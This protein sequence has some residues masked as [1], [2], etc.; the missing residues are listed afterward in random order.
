MGESVRVPLFTHV[1]ALQD[2]LRDVRNIPLYAQAV[3]C[4]HMIGCT[5]DLVVLSPSL[6][7]QHV[8]VDYLLMNIYAL[9]FYRKCKI[10]SVWF[11][12]RRMRRSNMSSLLL[13]SANTTTR[14]RFTL[15]HGLV[16]HVR[17]RLRASSAPDGASHPPFLQSLRAP[18][19]KTLLL[20]SYFSIGRCLPAC[21]GPL[22]P[23]ILLHLFNV[24]G[25]RDVRL[26]PR[27]HHL[28]NCLEPISILGR[29]L[30]YQANI[31]WMLIRD[32]SSRVTPSTNLQDY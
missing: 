30:C 27:F 22:M 12:K 14:V 5:S 4:A 17:F 7:F 16:L 10:N 21:T 20:T 13:I 29:G 32:L 18:E 28:T 3:I 26:V 6:S 15:R 11:A 8:L 31:N 19:K 23:R 9:H 25:C 2:G 24:A 1:G